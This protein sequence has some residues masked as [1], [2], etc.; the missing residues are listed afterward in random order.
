MVAV[1]GDVIEV[2]DDMLFINGDAQ[3]AKSFQTDRRVLSDIT[4]APDQKVLYQENLTGKKHWLMYNSKDGPIKAAKFGPEQVPADSVFVVGDN[5]DNS[6]DSRVF[7]A[8]PLSL[9]KGKAMFVLWSFNPNSRRFRPDR[10]GYW[11]Q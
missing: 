5:R 10:F 7:E 6:S 11:L 8:V 4:D 2:K 9:V 1:E 3:E